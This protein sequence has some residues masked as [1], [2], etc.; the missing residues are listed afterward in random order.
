[1]PQ[2]IRL[3][4]A[5]RLETQNK[6]K[7]A[8]ARY[9]ELAA[10]TTLSPRR[11]ASAL[12]GRARCLDKLKRTPAAMTR[13]RQLI[14]EYPLAADHS[15]GLILSLGARRRRARLFRQSRKVLEESREWL[16]LLT[17]LA[18]R[19]AQIPP[20]QAALY[21][22]RAGQALTRL[23]GEEGRQPP[24]GG[25]KLASRWRRLLERRH[26]AE[27]DAARRR[28]LVA[29]LAPT[30]ARALDGALPPIG[31]VDIPGKRGRRFF[32]YGALR[33]KNAPP[34]AVFVALHP[35]RILTEILPNHRQRYPDLAPIVRDLD[36]WPLGNQPEAGWSLMETRSI[37]LKLTIWFRGPDP[38]TTYSGVQTR[39][40]AWVIAL[41]LIGIL[42]GCFVILRAVTRELKQARQKSDFVSNVTH[43]LK[44]PLTSIRMFVETLQMGRFHSE[45]DRA[46]CLDRIARETGRLQRLIERVLE[47]S[48]IDRGVKTFDF[49]LN[50]PNSCLDRAI[51]LF[52]AEHT[53]DSFELIEQRDDDLPQV[54]LDLESIVEVVLNLLQNAYKYSDPPRKITLGA[55]TADGT[56]RIWVRDQGI[57][58]ERNQHK[59]IFRK[60]Y[61]VDDVLSRRADGAGLG[62]TLC[63]EIV[64]AHDGRV[65]LDSCPGRGSLFTVYLPLTSPVTDISSALSEVS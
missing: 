54:Q 6:L 38:S 63:S 21:R 43:E 7:Q 8:L 53:A 61:R 34:A 18:A 24:A 33:S 37:Q 19:R 17:F 52:S 36:E 35:E 28:E 27:A 45:A 10:E 22:K 55:T 60:F 40:F 9:T 14:E 23:L 3:L 42:L 32:F 46:E 39:S 51:R 20:E 64:A 30:A 2:D 25:R 62:L 13:Y 15:T 58:I 16:A 5:S 59:K 49:Q 47:F 31:H 12:L 4:R 50:D 56:L 41:A 1:L 48:K 11:R 44:T 65:A 26:A 57:G 29:L